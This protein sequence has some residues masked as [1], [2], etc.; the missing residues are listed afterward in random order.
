MKRFRLSNCREYICFVNTI[1]VFL[2][3][4]QLAYIQVAHTE[5]KGT[6][7]T[8]AVFNLWTEAKAGNENSNQFG[9]P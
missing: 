7:L 6:L 1:R 2:A 9:N 3:G 4:S 5:Q 8:S